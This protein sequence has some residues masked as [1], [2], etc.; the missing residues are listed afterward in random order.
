MNV[1]SNTSGKEKLHLD[2]HDIFRIKKMRPGMAVSCEKG[3]L[4]ITQSGDLRDYL[5]APG[6]NLVIKKH[7]RVLIEALRD[8]DFKIASPEKARLN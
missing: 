2:R 1:K 8:V 5:L 7:G 4:W 6:Q 3:I